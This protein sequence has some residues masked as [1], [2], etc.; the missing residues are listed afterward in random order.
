MIWQILRKQELEVLLPSRFTRVTMYPLIAEAIDDNA[1]AKC[2]RITFNFERLTWIDPVGIVVLSNLF[3]YLTRI[4]V[5][6]KLTNHT[7]NIEV[8]RFLD[9]SLF[10]ERYISKKI[11]A[12]SHLRTTTIP[13]RLIRQEKVFQF[14]EHDLIPW[15][16]NSVHFE[17]DS[18]AT[19]KM[20]FEEIFLNINHHSEVNIGCV[21]AQHYPHEKQIKI[22][23]SDFGVGI[24]TTV[25]RKK[26]D[27]D[28]KAAIELACQ[29]GFTTQSNVRNRGAGIPNLLRYVTKA[30]QGTVLITSGRGSISASLVGNNTNITSRN[31]NGFYPGTLVNVILR[32]D[33]FEQIVTDVL[34]E[35]FS[36][37]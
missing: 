3:E 28:D 33:T 1:D 15:I 17:P 12:G 36:W 30:N 9:D 8:I 20:C 22:A 32:T 24:P 14:L 35:D 31:V 10:F 11:F 26:P 37:L 13:L 19:I 7:N 27:L 6:V 18:L 4:G 16:G 2:E 34:P 23:V 21:F 5:K 25:R 29:E